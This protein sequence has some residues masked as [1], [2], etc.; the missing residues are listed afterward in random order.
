MSFAPVEIHHRC[1]AFGNAPTETNM[2]TT[3]AA[4]LG[5][6][7][8]AGVRP[9]TAGTWCAWYGAD[10][11]NCG[12]NSAQQCQATTMGDSAAYCSPNP[13][14]EPEPPSPSRRRP[15]GRKS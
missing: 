15:H 1:R 8:F 13:M 7:F 6:L 4:L 2:R 12:F 5:I 14:A 9:A 3:L 11:Y 10:T